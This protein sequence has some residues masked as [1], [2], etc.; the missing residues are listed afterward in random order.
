VSIIKKEKLKWPVIAM[1]SGLAL[2]GGCSS[3]GGGGGSDSS[4]TSEF[5]GV[6][7]DGYLAGATICADINRNKSC[8]S[9]EPTTTTGA[10]GV[11]SLALTAEQA[12]VPIVLQA[13]ENTIDE[14]T[15]EVVDP[16]LTYSAPAGS[17]V[18]NAIT[19]IIQNKVEE[20][21]ATDSSAASKTNAQLVAEANAAVR[22]D[23]GL[24]EAI[25]FVTTDFVALKS[26]DS[27]ETSDADKDLYATLHIVNQVVTQQI[28]TVV[29][30]AEAVAGQGNET[31]AF[32]AA[33]GNINQ[34]LDEVFDAAEVA[35]LGLS[36]PELLNFQASVL[37]A[38]VVPTPTA[39]EIQDQIEQDDAVEDLFDDE[40]PVV[41]GGTGGTGG[42]N[43]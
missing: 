29:P 21:L 11:W 35:T 39:Q 14:D 22:T 2:A 8:D 41:T 16:N 20:A 15:D 24:S 10:G 13:N 32:N 40:P 38:P 17:S 9:G 18:I 37:T 26:D 25:D 5:S 4:D 19:T 1:I 34:F 23:L 7:F 43:P 36:G 3:G 33:I 6:A 30:A 31:A 27:G 42:S 28:T 12:A